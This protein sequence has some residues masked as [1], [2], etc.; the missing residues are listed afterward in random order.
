M[1]TYFEGWGS[2][3]AAPDPDSYTPDPPVVTGYFAD[4]R[5]ISQGVESG[6]VYWSVM[7]I[8][9]WIDLWDKWDAGKA[10]EGDFK[11]PGRTSGDSWTSW[12]SLTAQAEEPTCEYAGNQVTNVRM[13]LIESQAP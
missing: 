5:P 10:G 6:V 11:V 13:R 9:H 4:G 1:S 8:A 2:T 12:R 7:T 3:I